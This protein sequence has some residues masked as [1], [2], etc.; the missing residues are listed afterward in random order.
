MCSALPFSKHSLVIAIFAVATIIF[1]IM[2]DHIGVI[3][4][5][6]VGGSIVMAPSPSS[7]FIASIGY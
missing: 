6:D 7:Y 1:K 3:R 2:K 4:R 5:Y